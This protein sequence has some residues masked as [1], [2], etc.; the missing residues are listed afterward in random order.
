MLQIHWNLIF[1]SKRVNEKLWS[2]NT[3]KQIS[4]ILV[5]L[6]NSSHSLNPLK[7]GFISKMGNSSHWA[8]FKSP[9]EFMKKWVLQDHFNNVIFSFKIPLSPFFLFS[10]SSVI[11]SETFPVKN[12]CFSAWNMGTNQYADNASEWVVNSQKIIFVNILYI[13]IKYIPIID[14][15]LKMDQNATL[16]DLLGI[17]SEKPVWKFKV[18]H[19]HNFFDR[20][21]LI[22]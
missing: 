13:R 18:Y 11:S 3:E 1:E 17:L 22:D 2:I 8:N 7:T 12:T 16:N 10:S 14:L 15:P 19:W 9:L 5:A 6:I 21:T 4:E 20:S